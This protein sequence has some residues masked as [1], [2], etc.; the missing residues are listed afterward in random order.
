MLLQAVV[1]PPIKKNMYKGISLC[2]SVITSCYV[3]IGVVG[4]WAFGNT[5]DVRCKLTCCHYKRQTPKSPSQCHDK[6]PRC[7]CD[8]FAS[9]RHRF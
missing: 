3:L 8:L 6:T 7:C 9:L 2:Y 1:G 5:A 4:Y